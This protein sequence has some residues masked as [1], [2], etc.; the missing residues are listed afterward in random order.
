MRNNLIHKSEVFIITVTA[1]PPCSRG[2]L[3]TDVSMEAL[4]T[5]IKAPVGH[6][7]LQKDFSAAVFVRYTMFYGFIL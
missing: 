1:R 5:A 6:R 2:H 3:Q 4:S 7:Q